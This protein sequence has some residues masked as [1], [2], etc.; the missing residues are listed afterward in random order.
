MFK[1]SIS[2]KWGILKS[3]KI[4]SEEGK[5]ALAALKTAEGNNPTVT[6]KKEICD[7]ID[8]VNCKQIYLVWDGKYVSKDDAKKYVME[9]PRD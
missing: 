1:D 4:E 2:L 7:L 9:Y 5:I 8:A 6:P 3:C